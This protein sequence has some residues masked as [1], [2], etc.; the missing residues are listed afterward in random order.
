[1]YAPGSKV[2]TYWTGEQPGWYT[3]TVQRTDPSGNIVV[4]YDQFPHW[5]EY[6]PAPNHVQPLAQ[7]VVQKPAYVVQQPPAVIIQKERSE[8]YFGPIS[9][10]ICLLG[11]PCIIC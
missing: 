9:L 6:V 7:Q 5:G 8:P 1:M 3:A 4:V 2:N 10:I 11:F